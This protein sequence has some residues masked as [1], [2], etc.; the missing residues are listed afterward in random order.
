MWLLVSK[1]AGSVDPPFTEGFCLAHSEISDDKIEAYLKTDYRF[2][3]G[4]KIVTL[5][6]DQ[7]SNELAQLFARS[8]FACGVFITAFNPFAHIQGTKNN[9]AAH[10]RLPSWPGAKLGSFI[11]SMRG[12]PGSSDEPPCCA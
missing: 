12:E 6:I 7:R 4:S 9:E 1:Q 8:G 11:F 5:H 10:E 3:E 2:G